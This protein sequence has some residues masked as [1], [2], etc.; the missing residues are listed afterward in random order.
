MSF[1]S[2]SADKAIFFQCWFFICLFI[3]TLA[4]LPVRAQDLTGEQDVAILNLTGTDLYGLYLAPAG[5]EKWGEDLLHGSRLRKGK[6]V[7]ITF[8]W[9][10]RALWWDLRVENKQGEAVIWKNVPV[11]RFFQL[12]LSFVGNTPR[13]QGK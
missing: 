13:I 11:R 1:F 9:K 2:V 6:K 4:I 5:T 12:T 3:L 10:A 8:P 7:S